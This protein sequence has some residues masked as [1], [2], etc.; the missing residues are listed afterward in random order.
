MSLIHSKACAYTLLEFRIV[1]FEFFTFNFF[2][3]FFMNLRI[4]KISNIFT[5]A[6]RDFYN[7]YQYSTSVFIIE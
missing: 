6:K 5:F 2:F 7:N 1:I 4:Y 3:L